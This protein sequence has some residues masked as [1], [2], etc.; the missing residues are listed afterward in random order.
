MWHVAAVRVVVSEE[1]QWD[2]PGSWAHGVLLIIWDQPCGTKL[3]ISDGM[4][5]VAPM[6]SI[7]KVA[8]INYGEHNFW[9]LLLFW[10]QCETIQ[11]ELH[12]FRM[13]ICFPLEQDAS[14]GM[15]E[16]QRFQVKKA[17]L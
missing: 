15:S 8:N 7:E 11:K 5:G 3:R 16:F 14:P 9:V 1:T 2:G 13:M 6:P 17:R 10:H 12:W 4:F